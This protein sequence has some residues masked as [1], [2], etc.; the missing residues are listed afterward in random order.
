MKYGLNYSLATTARTEPLSNAKLVRN[1]Q[2]VSNVQLATDYNNKTIAI[3]SGSFTSEDLR[4]IADCL[5]GKKNIINE[6]KIFC[7]S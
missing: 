5:D 1:V 2:L 6:F 7:I 4:K 3:M